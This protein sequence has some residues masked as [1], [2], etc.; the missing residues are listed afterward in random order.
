MS[1]NVRIEITVSK[2]LPTQ[3]SVPEII[4]LKTIQENAYFDVTHVYRFKKALDRRVMS[5]YRSS[6][7]K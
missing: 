2:E 5:A 7:I 3:N 1:I 6:L 4:R